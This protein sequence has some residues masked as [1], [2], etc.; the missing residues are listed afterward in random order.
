MAVPRKS[1]GFRKPEVFNVFTWYTEFFSISD[2][3]FNRA[4]LIP[5]WAAKCG[6]EDE[7]RSV[8]RPGKKERSAMRSYV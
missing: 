4:L 2:L 7:R 3:F 5:A 8:L 6:D 1:V